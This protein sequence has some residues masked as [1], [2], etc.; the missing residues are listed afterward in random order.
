MSHLKFVTAKE[1]TVSQIGINRFSSDFP[2][3]DQRAR[4]RQDT[5]PI[6]ARTDREDGLQSPHA[7]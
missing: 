2:A 6:P 3:A 7:P 5:C 4:G 1:T